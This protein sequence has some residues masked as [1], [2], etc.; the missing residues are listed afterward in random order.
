MLS[1]ANA[2]AGYGGSGLMACILV[3]LGDACLCSEWCSIWLCLFYCIIIFEWVHIV[4]LGHMSFLCVC[5]SLCRSVRAVETG[6]FLSTNHDAQF[7][8]PL[9][10]FIVDAR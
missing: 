5:L 8:H 6:R 4:D 2:P 7:A 9:S 10:T 3:I 1:C